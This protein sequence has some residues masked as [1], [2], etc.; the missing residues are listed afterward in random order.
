MVLV[1]VDDLMTLTQVKPMETAFNPPSPLE[2]GEPDS[3]SPPF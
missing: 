2:K 1:K 3:G